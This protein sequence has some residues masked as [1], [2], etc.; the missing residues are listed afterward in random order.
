MPLDNLADQRLHRSELRRAIP[1]G[2]FLHLLMR[3]S[4][5]LAVNGEFLRPQALVQAVQN[6]LGK[7]IVA[8]EIFEGSLPR[9]QARRRNSA[10]QVLKSQVTC[11]LAHQSLGQVANRAHMHCAVAK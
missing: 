8:A 1:L 5:H 2:V 7:L 9:L 4:Y 6:Q 10:R 3:A 11:H